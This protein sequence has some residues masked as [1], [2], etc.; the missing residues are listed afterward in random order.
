M[1]VYASAYICIL[2]V[3]NSIMVR[4]KDSKVSPGH[5]EMLAASGSLMKATKNYWGN[6]IKIM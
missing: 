2:V 1:F 3:Y 5:K 6:F 4:I